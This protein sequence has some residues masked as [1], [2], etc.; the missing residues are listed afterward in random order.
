M[1]Y[2]TT[3]IPA[4]K[5]FLYIVPIRHEKGQEITD[6]YAVDIIAWGVE[7]LPPDDPDDENDYWVYPITFEQAHSYHKGGK[8]AIWAPS[9]MLTVDH[10]FKECHT[11][12]A[13]LITLNEV[14]ND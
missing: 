4:E 9:K 13:I 2:P 8:F 10:H 1:S 3:I 12:E 7:I 14:W 11:K 6:F 5:G